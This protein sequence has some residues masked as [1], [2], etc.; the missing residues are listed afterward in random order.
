MILNVSKSRMHSDVFPTAFRKEVSWKDTYLTQDKNNT[1][2]FLGR[3]IRI[4]KKNSSEKN[5]GFSFSLEPSLAFWMLVSAH[6]R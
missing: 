1:A 3:S 5:N 6:W 2:T 4:Q